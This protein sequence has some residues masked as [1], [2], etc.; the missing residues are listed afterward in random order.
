M[1]KYAKIAS[2]ALSL[3]ML[4]GSVGCAFSDIAGMTAKEEENYGILSEEE[5]STIADKLPDWSDKTYQFDFLGYSALTDGTWTE[6]G[7]VY[8]SGEDFRNVNRII[9]YKEV[10]MTILLPQSA[11]AIEGNV[12]TNFSFEGSKLQEVMDMSV[13]AGL[14][15]VIVAD[16]RLYNLV[17]LDTDQTG[18][19]GEEKAFA[20][21]ADLDETVKAYMSPYVEHEAFY[22][23]MLNDEPNYKMFKGYGQVYK[24]IKRCYPDTY[25]FCNLF[26][27][28]GGSA[29]GGVFEEPTEEEI[30]KY[31]STS[32]PERL[33]AFEKY[34]K[35]FLDETGADYVMYD[36]YPLTA[37]KVYDNYVGGLQVAA[38]V[39]AERGVHFYF[40]SQTM[41][42]KTAGAANDRILSEEDLRWLN[43]MQLGFGVKQ[44]SYFTYFTKQSN[45]SS[46]EW[47][48]DGG[49]FIT[50][51][52][53]KTELY[54]T[55]Q[56]ILAENQTFAP[57]ILSFEYKTSAAYYAPLS[58]Y[59]TTNAAS[60]LKGNFT[61]VSSVEIDKESAL[62]SELYDEE[63]NL[64]MYMLQNIV[65]PL[66]KTSETYQK[67]TLRFNES[68]Q[69]ALVYKNAR[70]YVV[71]LKD[72]TYS[73][74]QQPGEAVYVVPFNV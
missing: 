35:A 4:L 73:V 44:I 50:H 51:L 47:F 69:Y 63:K 67:I 46:G 13:E 3:C 74:S 53:E 11:C 10:G 25:I 70:R 2:L 6:D 60:C 34:L 37:E 38:N 27:P 62:V 36:A 29:V 55:M 5:V 71:R 57:V 58:T 21:E 52:G 12:G 41:T 22:G 56:K 49:S 59:S 24:A 61:K 30:K 32:Y 54:Y 66:Y 18:I 15:K 65:N 48:V 8:S 23:V 28:V 17:A 39:C 72:N 31:A 43:N 42:M 1:K 20:S 26:P 45:S 16:Y 64:Y 33:A 19:I 14:S 40:A 68:Y 9:E 7:T